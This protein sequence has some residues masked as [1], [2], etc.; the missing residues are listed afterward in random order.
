MLDTKVG[1]F[2]VRVFWSLRLTFML[3]LQIGILYPFW[4]RQ[5]LLGLWFAYPATTL[6]FMLSMAPSELTSEKNGAVDYNPQ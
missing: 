4:T 5:R 2:E 3:D 1:Y 6:L